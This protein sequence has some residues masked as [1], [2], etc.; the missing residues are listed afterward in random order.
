MT[1][2]QYE[3]LVTPGKNDYSILVSSRKVMKISLFQRLVFLVEKARTDTVF[4]LDL[5]HT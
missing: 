5:Q 3:Q 4:G 2:E 1:D